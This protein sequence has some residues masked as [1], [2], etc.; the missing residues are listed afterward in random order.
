MKIV[1]FGIIGVGGMGTGHANNMPKVSEVKLTAVADVSPEALK[2]A[3]DKFDVPGFSSSTELIKSGLVDAVIVATPHYFHAPI[4]IEAMKAGLHVISEKP[5]TVRLSDA[6]EM[7]RVAKETKKIFAVMFNQR[8]EPWAQ[9]AKKVIDEGR[10]GELYRALLVEGWFRSQAYY[11]SATWRATWKGEGGGVLMNQAPH[12][13]DLFTWL[14]GLPSKV[15]A[16]VMTRN[17]K[18]EVEDEASAILTY[19]NGATGYVHESVNEAPTSS[20]MEFCGEKGKLVV[21]KGKVT[22]WEVK[23]G[24]R[25]YSDSSENMWGGPEVQ[26]S[27]VPLEPRESGHHAIVRNVALAIMEGQSLISPGVEAIK[28]LE[29]AD[30]MIL[31]GNTGRPVTVPVDRQK[32]NDF[33]ARKAAQSK[34]KKVKGP[35]K[36]ITDPSLAK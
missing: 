23:P 31:S 5:I 15:N 35:S 13:L 8:S 12:W 28:A 19:P 27:E 21:E 9:A 10:L 20:R 34:E 32:F 1:R 4:A 16:R 26:M 17:H 2:T 14:G 11:D 29:L 25:A 3:T 22:L 6:D 36:R 18:I 24:V 33:L 30:A 7:I